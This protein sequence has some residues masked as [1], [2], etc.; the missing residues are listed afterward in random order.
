VLTPLE[1]SETMRGRA[2]ITVAL[3]ETKDDPVKDFDV[4]V[5]ETK[6]NAIAKRQGDDISFEVPLGK[7]NNRVRV[8][9]RSNA[10]LLGDAKLE[11]TQ[12]G[13]GALDK[14]DTLFIIAV[15]V[16]KYPQMPKTCGAKGDASCDLA[17]AGAEPRPSPRRLRSR[18]AASIGK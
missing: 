16:D 13:D 17:F 2:A 4:F 18:W 5:N 8:V 14:R 11:I 15:G 9:A 1:G 6:V 3:A 12:N 7:G 10:D